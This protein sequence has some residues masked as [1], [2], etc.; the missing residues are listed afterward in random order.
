MTENNINIQTGTPI[1]LAHGA[2]YDDE[3]ESEGY[4]MDLTGLGSDASRQSPKIDFP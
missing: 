3:F 1:I 2:D 4:E